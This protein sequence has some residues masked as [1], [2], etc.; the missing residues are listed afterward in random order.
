MET[1]GIVT[2][3]APLVLMLTML[4][5]RVPI[6][7]ALGFTGFIG[8]WMVTGFDASMHKVGRIAFWQV[9]NYAYSPLVLFVFLGEIMVFTG[10]GG[11]LFEATSKWV[12]RIP[13]SLAISAIVASSLFGA[14]CGLSVAGALTIGE[15]AIPDGGGGVVPALARPIECRVNGRRVYCRIRWEQSDGA[16][17][18]NEE[19]PGACDY[20]LMAFPSEENG[21]A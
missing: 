8:F 11:R 6:G 16:G 20:T 1:T 3:I 13:G 15:L 4:F 19:Y 12:G 18:N 14:I 5:L 9:L 7:V 10:L 21:G 2:I 17:T